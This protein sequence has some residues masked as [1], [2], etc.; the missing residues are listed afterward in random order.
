METCRRAVAVKAPCPRTPPTMRFYYLVIFDHVLPGLLEIAVRGLKEH[1][2]CVFIATSSDSARRDCALG[3]C[4]RNRLTNKF[5]FD[6]PNSLSRG[7]A[8]RAHVAAGSRL[9]PNS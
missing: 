6:L 9:H 5:E 3:V 8:W 4:L 1:F 2:I 7:S